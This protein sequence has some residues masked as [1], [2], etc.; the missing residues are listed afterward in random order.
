MLLLHLRL[1]VTFEWQPSENHHLCHE[2][3]KPHAEKIAQYIIIPTFWS[4][5]PRPYCAL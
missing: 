4:Q 2:K 5:S 1:Q 3:A